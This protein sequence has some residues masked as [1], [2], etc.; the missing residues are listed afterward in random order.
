MQMSMVAGLA[1]P[2][3]ALGALFMKGMDEGHP[4][5]QASVVRG[6]GVAR[7]GPGEL[8]S[9]HLPWGNVAWE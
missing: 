7:S 5:H 4:L 9:P 3:A 6:Q 1:F 2:G 8:R